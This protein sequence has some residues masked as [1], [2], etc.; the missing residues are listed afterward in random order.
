MENIRGDEKFSSRGRTHASCQS[1]Y[2]ASGLALILQQEYRRGEG[3]YTGESES[4]ILALE[5]R[6]G[7][8]T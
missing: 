5:V 2:A 3:Q 1:R 7:E 8:S 6:D 4:E